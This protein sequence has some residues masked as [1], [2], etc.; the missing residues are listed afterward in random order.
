MT[1]AIFEHMIYPIASFLGAGHRLIMPNL[2]QLS[3]LRSVRSVVDE[4]PDVVTK[5]V[6][7]ELEQVETESDV[8]VTCPTAVPALFG[9]HGYAEHRDAVVESL[10]LAIR[11]TMSYEELRVRMTEDIVLRKPRMHVDVVWNLQ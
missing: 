2:R 8:S 6:G 5:L 9:E 11:A 4:F 10:V 1:A 7:R 3:D